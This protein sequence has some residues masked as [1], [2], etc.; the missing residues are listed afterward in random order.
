[1]T[2]AWSLLEKA[3][4]DAVPEAVAAARVEWLAKG[5]KQAD[6]MLETERTYERAVDTGDKTG[7]LTAYQA[8]NDFRKANADYDKTN[9]LG[10]GGS[11]RTWEKANR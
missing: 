11:E 9:F 3:R 8:L 1:M 7:F 6:L 10:L 5:L 2:N 4:T